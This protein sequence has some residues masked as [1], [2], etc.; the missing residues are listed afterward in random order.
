MSEDFEREYFGQ[1]KTETEKN[2]SQDRLKTSNRYHNMKEE[3]KRK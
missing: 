2:I 1:V 3:I